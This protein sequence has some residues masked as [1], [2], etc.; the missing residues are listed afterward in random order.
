MVIQAE[1]LRLALPEVLEACPEV[2]EGARSSVLS[3]ASPRTE[4]ARRTRN[5][6]R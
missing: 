1:G 4:S 5:G 3:R 2:V 6:R